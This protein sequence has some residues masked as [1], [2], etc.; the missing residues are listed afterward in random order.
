MEHGRVESADGA[1]PGAEM[2]Q[3]PMHYFDSRGVFR[4]Y[5]SRM[6]DDA[7]QVWRDAAGFSQRFTGRFADAGETILGRWQLCRD[8]VHWAD[9]LAITYRRRQGP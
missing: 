1:P 2:S 8:G 9:D 7:W 3:L 4:V 5:Q 6:T